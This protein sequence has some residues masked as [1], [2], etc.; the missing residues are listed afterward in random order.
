[1]KE[2]EESPKL[3]IRSFFFQ[4]LAPY[5]PAARPPDTKPCRYSRVGF[6]KCTATNGLT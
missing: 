2:I 4:L 5:A 1:M 3:I 6:S